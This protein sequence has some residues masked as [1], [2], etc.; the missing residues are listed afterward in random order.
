MIWRYTYLARLTVWE[1]HMYLTNI[2]DVEVSILIIAA[3]DGRTNSLM[4]NLTANESERP[5]KWCVF[6]G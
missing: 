4:S 1:Q 3:T 6:F 5:D 2:K